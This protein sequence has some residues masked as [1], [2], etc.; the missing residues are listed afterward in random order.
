M[1]RIFPLA[2]LA[3]LS[4]SAIGASMLATYPVPTNL[5]NVAVGPDGNLF[6]TSVDDGFLY[7]I[8]LGGLSQVFGQT[9][10]PLTGAAFDAGGDLIVA[11][12]T[13]IY[14]FQPDGTRSFVTDITGAQSL[15]GVTPFSPETFLVADDGAATVWQVNVNT[16]STRAWLTGDLLEPHNVDV[17]IGPNGIKLFGGAAYITNTGAGTI[18]RVPIQPDGSAGS[19]S[20]YASGL[21]LDDFAFGADGSLFLATQV[22]NSVIRLFPDGTQLIIA[23]EADG[24]LGNS[25]LAFGRTPGDSQD[26]YVVNNGGAYE[27]LPGGQ[28]AAT[29]VRLAAGIT[30]ADPQLQTIPEP[31]TALFGKCL[32]HTQPTAAT[33]RTL[34]VH[35]REETRCLNSALSAGAESL[36]RRVRWT[37]PAISSSSSTARSAMW[38][39]GPWL[40]MELRASFLR[41]PAVPD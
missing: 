14:R 37:A 20:V 40:R 35:R 15:N 1:T 27:N 29:V 28:R 5:E 3:L 36:V 25:A 4:A 7:K 21:S 8:S 17:P 33:P 34:F 19:P 23:S 9:P 24:L 13:S 31:G 10:A 18:I 32:E 12:G 2:Q 6:V 11:S 30:G 26:I 39:C 22:N 41:R 38:N 16:G